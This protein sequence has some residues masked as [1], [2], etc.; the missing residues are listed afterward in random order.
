MFNT[1][2]KI[3]VF[4]NKCDLLYDSESEF[5]KNKKNIEYKYKKSIDYKE[6]YDYADAFIFG[7]A[8]KGWGIDEVKDEIISIN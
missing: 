1:H 6:L 4:F 7:S 2:K 8:L 3:I 5:L